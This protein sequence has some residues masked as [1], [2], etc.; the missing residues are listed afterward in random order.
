MARQAALFDAPP[1]HPPRKLMHVRDAGNGEAGQVVQFQ[2][3]RCGHDS[4][5]VHGLGVAEAKRGIPCPRCN[6]SKR[7]D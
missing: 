5:W 1:R 6:P 4:G 3:D 7:Q 2:C